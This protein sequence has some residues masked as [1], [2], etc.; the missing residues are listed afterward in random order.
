MCAQLAGLQAEHG[1]ASYAGQNGKE[2]SY[3]RCRLGREGE[4][5]PI[6]R[7]VSRAQGSNYQVATA[8]LGLHLPLQR[9]RLLLTQGCTYLAAKEFSSDSVSALRQALNLPEVPTQ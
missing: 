7:I 5:V 8:N 4:G 6:T 3:T 2:P 9:L 1:E